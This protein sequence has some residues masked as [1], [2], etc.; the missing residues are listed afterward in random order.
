M[1]IYILWL[2][3][4]LMSLNV[5]ARLYPQVNIDQLEH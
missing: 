5:S 4:E 3:P 2:A 1:M